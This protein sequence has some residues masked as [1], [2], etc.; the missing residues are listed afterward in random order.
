MK[1]ATKNTIALTIHSDNYLNV[2]NPRIT[3]RITEEG[4]HTM[5]CDYDYLFEDYST[6][7]IGCGCGKSFDDAKAMLYRDLKE[8]ANAKYASDETKAVC[9]AAI[10]EL[11]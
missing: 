9:A 3:H 5:I 7:T 10:A 11:R 4:Y 2:H 6:N 1:T 8:T